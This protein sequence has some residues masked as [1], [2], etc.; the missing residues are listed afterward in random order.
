MVTVRSKTKAQ[1][2]DINAIKLY[3]SQIDKFKQKNL[4]KNSAALTDRNIEQILTSMELRKMSHAI[5][6]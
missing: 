2:S 1:E 5:K 6:V 3:T 4:D